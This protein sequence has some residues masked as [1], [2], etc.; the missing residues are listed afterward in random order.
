[1]EADDF[2]VIGFEFCHA[3]QNETGLQ[4]SGHHWS[5]LVGKTRVLKT[6]EPNIFEWAYSVNSQQNI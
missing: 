5:V 1:M 2:E 6:K 3:K 4:H